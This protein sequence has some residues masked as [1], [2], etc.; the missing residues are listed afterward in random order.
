MGPSSYA[1]FVVRGENLVTAVS[2]GR[3]MRTFEHFMARIV[4]S[5][6]KAETRGS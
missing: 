6:E 2:Y 5:P 4:D 1:S 3:V